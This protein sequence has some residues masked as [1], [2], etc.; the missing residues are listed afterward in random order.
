MLR[1][2]LAEARSALRR[3][4][5][6]PDVFTR[7]N[8]AMIWDASRGA[9]VADDGQ[10]DPTTCFSLTFDAAFELSKTN[11]AAECVVTVTH[12]VFP[13]NQPLNESRVR[14]SSLTVEAH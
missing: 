11:D 14:V 9:A 2:A 3:F 5:L 12:D 8:E 10:L 4:E 7:H 6:M 1:R 13:R